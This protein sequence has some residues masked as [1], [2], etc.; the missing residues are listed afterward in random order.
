MRDS[1]EVIPFH[2]LAARL[3]RGEVIHDEDFDAI[4]PPRFRHLSGIHWTPVSIARRAAEWLVDRPGRR[5][6]DVGSGAGKF[7][8]VGSLTTAGNFY[9]AEQ[10]ADLVQL[11]QELSESYRIPRVQFECRNIIEMDWWR[12]DA[13]YLYNPFCENLH[14]PLRI[15]D[16]VSLSRERYLSYTEWTERKLQEAS[17]GTRVVIYHEFGGQ[18]PSSYDLKRLEMVGSS[19]LELW[20]KRR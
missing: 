13:I 16:S 12:Y 3:S 4:F 18:M 15:D 19:K 17:P 14:P 6:L 7:C 2:E 10:R 20:V 8:I 5:V 1:E 9:G 11:S